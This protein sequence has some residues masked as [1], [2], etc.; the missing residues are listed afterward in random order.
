MQ[1]Y[2][3]DTALPLKEKFEGDLKKEI[4]KLQRYRDQIKTWCVLLLLHLD[5]WTMQHRLPLHQAVPCVWLPTPCQ[6]RS[7][8][9]LQSHCMARLLSQ[10]TLQDLQ[11]RHQGQ[12]Q[13][14]QCTEGRGAA[15]GTLQSL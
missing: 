6:T 13:P 15:D 7:V 8:R 9:A 12:N 14:H 3:A 5:S 4:K 2:D 1:V 11:L 10:K